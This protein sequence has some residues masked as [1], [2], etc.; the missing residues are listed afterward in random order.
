MTGNLTGARLQSRK[1]IRLKSEYTHLEVV[2]KAWSHLGH[3][4][5]KATVE[6]KSVDTLFNDDL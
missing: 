2:S 1:Y 4:D 6:R 3:V 5:D